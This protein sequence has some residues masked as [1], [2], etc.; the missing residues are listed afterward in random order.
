MKKITCLIVACTLLIGA[1]AQTK[2]VSD[3]LPDYDILF[4]EFA[5]FL[6]SLLKP[7]SFATVNV[8][9]GTG[10]FQYQTSRNTL[11]E[12]KR[13][14]ATPAIGYFH[15]SG[16]GISAA[17][18]VMAD[19]GT[20]TWYQ[21]AATASYDYL[22]NRKF[23]TGVSFTH[24]FAKDSLPFYTS[25]LNNQANAY[26]TYRGWWLKPVLAA[27]YGWGSVT[28][29]EKRKE[30]IKLLKGKPLNSTITT[31]TTESIS[32]LSLTASAKH[33]FYWLHVFTKHDYIRLTPQVGL[34]GGT[35]K[36]GLAE[37]NTAYITEKHSNTAIVYDTQKDFISAHSQFQLLL[38]SSRLRAE[39]ARGIFFI[40]PQL[41]FDY[42]IPETKNNLEVAF[43]LNAGIL[44]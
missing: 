29:V 40:Q 25:P 24:F 2:E 4:N 26:F 1:H 35:Q 30:K 6:D 16:L 20:F 19:A 10:H 21:T 14:I 39:Y 28:T 38:L 32:D 27:G 22:K 11:Q 34:T 8:G 31:E 9:F 33:D 12:K 41:F 23:M 18:S 44:F 37:T 15:K 7:R 5:H 17:G 3:T 36:Y 13:F 42:Y 43:V